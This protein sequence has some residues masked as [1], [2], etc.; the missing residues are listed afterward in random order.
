MTEVRA[1]RAVLRV[2]ADTFLTD[3]TGRLVKS[4]LFATCRELSLLHS[5]RGIISP[6]AISPLFL[7]GRKEL[8]LD[9]VITPYYEV[10]DKGETRTLVPV[11][12]EG[13]YVI[14]IGGEKSIV[15]KAQSCINALKGTYIMRFNNANIQIKIEKSEDV[16]KEI[17]NKEYSDKIRIYLKS[18]TLIFNIYTRSRL[19][20]FSP[21]AIEV[22]MTPY[23]I[24]TNRYT[25]THETLL[26]AA[27]ILGKLVET[28]YTLRTIKPVFIPFK[29]KPEVA[30]QGIITYIIDTKNPQEQRKIKDLITITEI[31][32]VG[33]SRLNGFGTTVTA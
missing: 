1:L 15:K 26:Q 10:K 11:R 19:P 7:E 22:L 31:T 29:N 16:T 21:S 30:L 8:S 27:P 25:L 2:E 17:I 5:M 28:Y 14:H 20:K 9:K 4:F 32:G 33:E 3:Y 23:M 18:P 6:L 13:E 24:A 12:P